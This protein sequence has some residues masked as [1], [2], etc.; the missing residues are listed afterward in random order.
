MATDLHIHILKGVTE[1]DLS[2]FF[3]HVFGSKWFDL[4]T[5]NRPNSKSHK[6]VVN[7][8]NI[9]IGEVSWLKAAF[10]DDEDS[11]VPSTVAKIADL[12]GEE[13]PVLTDE[14]I[15]QIIV[16]FNLPNNT[17]KLDGVRDGDGFMLANP[18][19]VKAF[20]EA[21]KGERIFTVSW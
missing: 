20:L 7:T 4:F 8:P 19:N 17:A 2:T 13:L 1:K 21:Y 9:W 14:L 3:S 5:S 15:T 11:F 16:A 6:K 18:K 10:L 12:I